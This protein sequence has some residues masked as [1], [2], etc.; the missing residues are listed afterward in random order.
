MT[1]LGELGHSLPAAQASTPGNLALQ[2]DAAVQAINGDAVD[3]SS[4]LAS[5][6]AAIQLLSGEAGAI[7]LYAP[8]IE[9]S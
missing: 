4:Y 9:Y 6:P 7:V 5:P 3:V 2:F 8:E 1:L